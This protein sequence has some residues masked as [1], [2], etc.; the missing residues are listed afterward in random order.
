VNINNTVYVAA[1]NL[2]EVQVW[3]EGSTK[4]SK[5]ISDNMFSPYSLFVTINGDIYVDN[6]KNNNR[7]DKW[8]LNSIS[9]VPVMDVTNNCFD[10]F[11]DSNN[12]LY[13]SLVDLHQVVNISLK[14]ETKTPEIVAGT[15]SP[16]AE[17]NMLHY[18]QGIFVSANFDL[19]VAD[20]WNNRVQRFR[21]GELVGQTVVGATAI[22]TVALS[23]PNGIVLDAGGYLFIADQNNNRIVGSGPNGFRCMVGCSNVDGSAMDELS[24]PS[25][26][27]FDNYGN[28]FVADQGNSRIQ[29]FLLI[30]NSIGKCT[31]IS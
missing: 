11:V 2:N 29:K 31:K 12:T 10:L 3:Q 26:L 23:C 27:S 22:G 13:C 24:Y 15:G 4:P 1:R 8:T 7:V 6:G 14:R 19:Y 9:S 25:A 21:S 18:P 5:T 16:G 28:I 20:C 17:A 30:N